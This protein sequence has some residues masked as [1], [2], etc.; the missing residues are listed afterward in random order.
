MTTMPDLVKMVEM[1]KRIGSDRDR[2]DD[3]YDEDS[4]LAALCRGIVGEEDFTGVHRYLVIAT[5]YAGEGPADK[6]DFFET[7]AAAIKHMGDYAR[8]GWASSLYDLDSDTVEIIKERS[9][10]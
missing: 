3:E 4:L 10:R 9:P 5:E 2:Y 1:A 6:A 8:S 7:Q